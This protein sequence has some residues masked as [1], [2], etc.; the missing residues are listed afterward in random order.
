MNKKH[1]IIC[2]DVDSTLVTCEGLDW[3]AEQK[4]IG[5][6]VKVLTQL[7]M[8]GTVPMQEVFEKKLNILSPTRSEMKQV[9]EHYCQSITEDAV[10]V[11]DVLQALK[12]EIWLITGGFAPAIMPL[13][14]KLRIPTSNIMTNVIFF[15]DQGFYKGIDVT[16]QL[17]NADGKSIHVQTL[18]RGRKVA[19]VGDGVTDLATKPFVKTFI[20]Y[21][22]VVTR[23]AVEQ[24][25]VYFIKQRS[26][27]PLL[28]YVLTDL[29]IAMLPDKQFR[30]IINKGKKLLAEAL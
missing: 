5:D 15:N 9:G 19:F 21:G 30:H 23:K 24:N 7:S 18:G 11:I 12:K 8:E 13:A 27:A 25:S 2:F 3:L 10:G 20:G 28:Q 26:L 22:G 4:K 6:K 17:A 29:E 1:D 16:N 14:K